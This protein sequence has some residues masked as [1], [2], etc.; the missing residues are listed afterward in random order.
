MSH[1]LRYQY[2]IN[3]KSIFFF[4]DE[5]LAQIADFFSQILR[6]EDEQYNI[7]QPYSIIQVGWNYYKILEG[8]CLQIVSLDYSKNPFEDTTEDLSLALTI[9][10]MQSDLLHQ[11]L[12]TP[13]ETSFKDTML[14]RKSALNAPH[15]F[16]Q[17]L[18]PTHENDSGWY[19]GSIDDVASNHPEDY[20]KIHT[21]QLLSLCKEALGLMPLP[22]GTMGIF[23]N[24]KLIEL[25][26]QDNHTIFNATEV[27]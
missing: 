1:L 16:L 18:K 9:F 14:I 5:L 13:Q 27:I 3:N 23:E 24:G 17:R 12:L 8:D 19:M 21:Y 11:T 26:D 7:L 4:C 15:I 20:M 22:V 6:S 2:Q 25:V 10:K